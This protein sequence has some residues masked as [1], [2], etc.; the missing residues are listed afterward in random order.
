MTQEINTLGTA[1]APSGI[2]LSAEGTMTQ[3]WKEKFDKKFASMYLL[4][5]ERIIELNINLLKGFISGLLKEER[6]AVLSEVERGVE[7]IIDQ[8]ATWYNTNNHIPNTETV[9]GDEHW[10]MIQKVVKDSLTEASGRMIKDISTIINN[11]R[12]K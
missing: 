8:E 4:A 9:K 10:E 2:T 6:N 7:N 3:D 11:L 5:D 1:H 12:I